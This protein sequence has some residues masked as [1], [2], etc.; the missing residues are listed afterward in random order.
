MGVSHSSATPVHCG[1][2]NA[3]QITHNDVFHECTK[4]IENDCH[5]IC[6]HVLQGTICLIS[7]SSVDQIADICTKAHSLGRF[8]NLV[9]K[10]QLADLLPP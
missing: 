9:S 3:M 6:H 1:N 8:H 2:R 10:L 5:F 4:H 7:V